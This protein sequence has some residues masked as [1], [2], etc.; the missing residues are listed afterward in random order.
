MIPYL[1]YYSLHYYFANQQ[2]DENLQFYFYKVGKIVAEGS[3]KALKLYE[4][5][6]DFIFTNV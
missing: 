4:T 3:Y 2:Y 5:A 6:Y 1:L